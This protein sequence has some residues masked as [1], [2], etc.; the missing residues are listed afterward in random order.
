MRLLPV[1]SFTFHLDKHTELPSMGKFHDEHFGNTGSFSSREAKST[2]E[3]KL[4]YWQLG[5]IHIRLVKSTFGSSSKFKF[6]P[7]VWKLEH[8][9]ACSRA[10]IKAHKGELWGSAICLTIINESRQLCMLLMCPGEPGRSLL[11]SLLFYPPTT[12][13]QHLLFSGLCPWEQNKLNN[14]FLQHLMNINA[15][16]IYCLAK[17]DKNKNALQ[18]KRTWIHQKYLATVGMLVSS[19]LS[20][21]TDLTSTRH[22]LLG[23]RILSYHWVFWKGVGDSLVAPHGFMLILE[24]HRLAVHNIGTRRYARAA[25]RKRILKAEGSFLRKLCARISSV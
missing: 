25:F 5:V 23:P 18:R 21:N 1:L 3:Q 7:C 6:L 8:A 19:S 24:F 15:F 9:Q 20:I 13:L 12:S 2:E 11:S 10:Q 16:F 14:F 22:A 4:R 17:Y